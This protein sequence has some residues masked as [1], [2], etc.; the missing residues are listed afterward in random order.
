MYD[1]IVVPVDGSDLSETALPHAVALARAMGSCVELVRAVAVPTLVGT[2]NEVALPAS[3]D[4]TDE[5]RAVEEYLEGLAEPIR[6]Q[7]V[8][9]VCKVLQGA[10]GH[11]V[12][13]YVRRNRPDLLVIS[14][15]GRHGL[16]RWLAGSTAERISRRAPCPVLVVRPGMD[17]P[18]R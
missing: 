15:H 17:E 8:R 1:R 9:V 18:G 2:M 7:G 14:F 4:S 13:Q 11:V 3:F 5:T 16:R 6:Q 10:P 12:T